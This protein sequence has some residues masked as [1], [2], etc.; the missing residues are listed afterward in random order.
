MEGKAFDDRT[1]GRATLDEFGRIEEYDW[2]WRMPNGPG[3][4]QLYIMGGDL[5]PGNRV[6]PA[7]TAVLSW[8]LPPNARAKP[9]KRKVQLTSNPRPGY[10]LGAFAMGAVERSFT[11]RIYI[12]WPDMLAFARSASVM[13]FSLMDE[14]NRL[15][16]HQAVDRSDVLNAETDIAGMLTALND[17]IAAYQTACSKVDDI[18]NRD[19][20][21]D[22][23]NA[24]LPT[25]AG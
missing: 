1:W 5:L 6:G 20:I 14:Q 18:I 24:P 17:K 7:G 11:P 8:N 22:R 3:R 19:I 21:V 16:D 4:Y 25:R 9:E 23:G 12:Y 13:N 10:V 2:T 15:I